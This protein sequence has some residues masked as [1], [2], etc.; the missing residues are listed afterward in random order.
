MSRR[1][2]DIKNYRTILN[3]LTSGASYASAVTAIKA[4]AV[5]ILTQPH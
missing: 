4:P 3:N 1:S 5:S 2:S